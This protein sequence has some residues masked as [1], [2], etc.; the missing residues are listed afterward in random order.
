[1][2]RQRY[3][4]LVT[5]DASDVSIRILDLVSEAAPK[6]EASD[7]PFSPSDRHMHSLQQRNPN[8]DHPP[9]ERNLHILA[10]SSGVQV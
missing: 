5:N 1:M 9:I 6:S 8:A 2:S 10:G 4:Q 3:H 7:D